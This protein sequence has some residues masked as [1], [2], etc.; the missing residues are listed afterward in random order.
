M[1]ELVILVV[2]AVVVFFI[3]RAVRGMDGGS[4]YLPEGYELWTIACPPEVKDAPER[5]RAFIDDLYSSIA[6]EPLI[7]QRLFWSEDEASPPL[8]PPA[9][10]AAAA[11]I[12]IFITNRRRRGLCRTPTTSPLKLMTKYS[13]GRVFVTHPPQTRPTVT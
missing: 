5:M 12:L 6:G 8:P 1:T 4:R 10:A 7:I 9:A 2:L 13:P 3:V 11:I